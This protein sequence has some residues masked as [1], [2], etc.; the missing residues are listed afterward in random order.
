MD[1]ERLKARLDPRTTLILGNVRE[2]VPTFVSEG[3]APPIGF[4]SMDL[5]L[6]SSTTQ[7]LKILT[8]PDTKRLLRTFLYFDDVELIFNHKF[9]GELLAIDEFNESNEMMKIDQLRGFNIDRPFPEK[10]YLKMMYVAHDLSAIAE[11]PRSRRR[12]ST[13]SLNLQ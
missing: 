2:T 3:T 7:A 6:Y 9:A 5:D 11:S 13:M 1:I 4:I 12:C 10:A 8:L